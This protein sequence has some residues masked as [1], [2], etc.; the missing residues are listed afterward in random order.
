[1][2]DNAGGGGGVAAQCSEIGNSESELALG[3]GEPDENEENCCKAALGPNYTSPSRGMIRD[4]VHGYN[5]EVV[6]A[7]PTNAVSRAEES[8]AYCVTNAWQTNA[9]PRIGKVK[10]DVNLIF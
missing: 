6:R 9:R 7:G 8:Q 2:A 1:M 4:T 3:L 5:S 10:P